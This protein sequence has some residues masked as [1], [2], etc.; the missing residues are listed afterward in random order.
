MSNIPSLLD[1]AKFRHLVLDKIESVAGFQL[2]PYN[3]VQLS[4]YVAAD[5]P[6]NVVLKNNGVTV[7]TL[8]LAYDGSNNLTSIVTN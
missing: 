3:G 7:A 4:N 6:Q 1:T 8:T 5:K 2:P